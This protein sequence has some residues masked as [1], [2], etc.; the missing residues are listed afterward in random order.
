[1]KTQSPMFRFGFRKDSFGFLFLAS[2][3]AAS[4]GLIALSGCGGSSVA[5]NDS[6]DS[7]SEIAVKAPPKEA[8]PKNAIAMLYYQE[9]SPFNTEFRAGAADAAKEREVEVEWLDVAKGESQ[10]AVFDRAVKEKYAAICVCPQEADSLSDAIT[11]ATEAKIPVVV[12]EQPVAS[13]VTEEDF[14]SMVFVATDHAH[15]GQVLAEQAI[16]MIDEDGKILIVG[17]EMGVEA[18]RAMNVSFAIKDSKIEV[19]SAL[20]ISTEST[21]A[22]LSKFAEDN[23]ETSYAIVAVS[24]AGAQEVL[25]WKDSDDGKEHTEVPLLG[26]GSWD[27]TVEAI[28]S[29]ELAAVVLEDPNGIGAAAVMTAATAKEGGEV[30]GLVT[31]GEHLVTADNIEDERIVALLKANLR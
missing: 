22:A 3:A 27:G 29:G 6:G 4:M 31:T 5:E 15:C 7:S 2:I 13:I 1:M 20:D 28:E 16:E 8:P 24:S 21:A 30:S 11:K 9:D 17:G 18:D 25:A 12:C 19:V 26:F 10:S 23:E 14:E